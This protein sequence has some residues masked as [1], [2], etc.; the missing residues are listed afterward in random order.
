MAQLT[1]IDVLILVRQCA[2]SMR[3]E[4][5]TDLRR[6]VWMADYLIKC[7]KEE[8]DRVIVIES[9]QDEEEDHA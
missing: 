4:G 6:L 9:F 1:P 5:E 2:Q 8:A 7:V 3:E